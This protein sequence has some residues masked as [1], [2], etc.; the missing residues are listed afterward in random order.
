MP[1]EG[2][3]DLMRVV[4]DC[5]VEGC[6]LAPL[7]APTNIYQLITAADAQCRAATNANVANMIE[8]ERHWAS[9][10]I[11]CDSKYVQRNVCLQRDLLALHA[12]DVRNKA[13]A[14]ALEAFYQL[15]GLEARR[16]YLDMAIDE[17]RKSLQ[18]ATGLHE[19]D[20][21]APIDRDGLAV[22]L[23]Q[24]EDQRLQLDYL[25]LQLN[26]QLQKLVG[27]PVSEHNFFFPEVDWTPELTPLDADAE[28]AVALP[29]RYEMR[30]IRLVLCKLQKSTL[31]VA[32]GVLQ[33]ADGTLGTVEPT[34]GW[35]HR[36]RCIRCNSHEVDVR[37]RQLA[38]LYA[39]AEQLATAEVKG[40]V[41]QVTLQQQRVALAREAVEARRAALYELAKQRDAQDT[42][43]F[44]LSQA[45]TRLYTAE[46]ELIEQVVN[47]KVALA[48]LRRAQG[49]LAAECGYE[50]KLCC[51]DGCCDGA[52]MH[53]KPPTCCPGDLPCT[54]A[55]CRRK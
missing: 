54:C 21:A 25:R 24:L 36:L 49:A 7:P 37:C 47:L 28:L 38:M 32:R 39:D 41:Y 5:D 23:A 53:C 22:Q 35:I 45:R 29:Q 4:P 3:P 44:E 19:A 42:P 11:E 33:V 6:V 46:S 34:E 17:T 52:C 50:P 26:G 12:A 48:Q 31:R 2:P 43:V 18:R 1:P 8:L 16:H 30:G 10:V 14:S 13:A 51:D 9:I 40:A 27:C 55:K 20:L 15:A